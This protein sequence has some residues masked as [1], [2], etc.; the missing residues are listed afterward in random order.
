MLVPKI[1]LPRQPRLKTSIDEFSANDCKNFFEFR[2][3]YLHRLFPL[4]HFPEK[5]VLDGGSAMSGEE[6]FL[7]GLY[8]L[9]SGEDQHNISRNVFGR[10]QT[11][12]YVCHLLR[13]CH[14]ALYGGIESN[15]FDIT[16]PDD[17]LEMYLE[18]L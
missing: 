7:R 3:H 2:Q 11:S 8:E 12:L 4:L 18:S 1:A 5:C 17:M 9:V 15:Y 13:N 16:L 10:K 14:V 6:V